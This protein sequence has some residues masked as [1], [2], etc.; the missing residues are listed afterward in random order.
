MQQFYRVNGDSTQLRG[1]SPDI[2]LPSLVA[3]MDLGESSLKYAVSFDQI[4]AVEYQPLQG[5]VTPA[6]LAQLRA[7]SMDRRALS[8]DWD[9]LRGEIRNY[10]ARKKESGV[11]LNETSLRDRTVKTKNAA[12]TTDTDEDYYFN[13]VLAIVRDYVTSLPK[14]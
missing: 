11:P 3:H 14:R 5:F 8:E 6:V 12:G 2:V 13:E 9:R 7:D 10:L 4:P 1:V